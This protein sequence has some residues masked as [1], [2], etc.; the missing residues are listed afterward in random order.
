MIAE[1][2]VDIVDTGLIA[3]PCL[4]THCMNMMNKTCLNAMPGRSYVVRFDV[5]Q[6]ARL[7]NSGVQLM[8]LAQPPLNIYTFSAIT[9]RHLQSTHQL[10]LHRDGVS[11][12]RII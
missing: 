3:N 10:G 11:S 2:A 1:L 5:G 6:P 7:C 4:L 8:A 12:E 9:V